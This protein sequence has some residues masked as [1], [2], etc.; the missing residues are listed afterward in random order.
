MHLAHTKFRLARIHLFVRL[1]KHVPCHLQYVLFFHKNQVFVFWCIACVGVSCKE[2][3]LWLVSREGGQGWV[4]VR[5]ALCANTPYKK[6]G[7]T[8]PA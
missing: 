1:S 7:P 6:A 4:T 5:Y 2:F 3:R 8:G